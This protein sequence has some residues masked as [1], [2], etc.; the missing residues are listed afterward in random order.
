MR[1]STVFGLALLGSLI[2]AANLMAQP[3]PG[4]PG[5]GG[6]FGMA[7]DPFQQAIV[8]LGDLNLR[9]DFNLTVEQK[10][11]LQAVR[12]EVKTMEDK[13]RTDHAA[14]LKKIQDD[15][16]TARQAQDQEKMRE[17]MTA[18]RDLMQTMPKTDDAAQKVKALLTD[19]QA[20]ALEARINERQEEMRARMGGMPGRGGRG[21]GGGGGGGGQ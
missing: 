11:K 2:M 8:A 7:Q 18:R 21:G 17:V 16:A 10:Q 15:A 13:W 9:P 5:G 6:M 14:E 20:K 12:D 19:D 3:A 1:V 4:G